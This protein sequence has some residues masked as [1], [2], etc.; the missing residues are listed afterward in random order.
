MHKPLVY[1]AA[2]Q[3][4]KLIEILDDTSAQS[5]TVRHLRRVLLDKHRINWASP[6]GRDALDALLRRL[7]VRVY[8]GSGKSSA[9]T[10]AVSLWRA[11]R[12]PDESAVIIAGTEKKAADFCKQIRMTIL[13]E[14]YRALFPDRVPDDTVRD[15]TE[16]W[17]RLKGRSVPDREASIMCFGYKVDV[18]SYHFDRFLI[19]DLVTRDNRVGV[20]LD[21][22]LDFIENMSGLHNPGKRRPVTRV[23]VGT[24]WNEED[25]DALLRAMG[26]HLSLSIPIEVYPYGVKDIRQRGIP[27]EPE[28]KDEQGIIELQ[29]DTLSKKDEGSVAWRANYL[30]D[31]SIAGG[32]IFPLELLDSRQWTPG[33]GKTAKGAVEQY[34]GVPKLDE[35]RE[36]IRD[37][38]DALQYEWTK[39][40]DLRRFVGCDQAWSGSGD[41][42]AVVVLG[43]DRK[44]R[45]YVLETKH[46]KGGENM[47]EALLATH[48]R[49][50]PEKIGLEKAAMQEA[51]IFFLKRDPRFRRFKNKVEGVPLNNQ[52][53]QWRARNGVADPM[54]SWEF[55]LDPADSTTI[56]QLKVWNPEDKKAEDHI[57]DALSIGAWLVKRPGNKKKTSEALTRIALAAQRRT[58]PTTGIYLGG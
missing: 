6:E 41:D 3:T 32:R 8:R 47:I 13:S 44:G 33:E 49:W 28:W 12:D 9:I 51:T 20:E 38:T 45:I 53:K 23:H 58:D 46:G 24:R 54:W 48:E 16:Q 26:G 39:V 19:D 10:H 34:V 11:T 37:E 29:A 17:I 14:A 30:L 18:T 50:K 35:K 42:W 27:T 56:S 21:R 4:D 57:I 40:S 31:P 1:A 5:F 43:V 55:F 36:P 22:A 2:G 15:L 52:S 7:N 25:D